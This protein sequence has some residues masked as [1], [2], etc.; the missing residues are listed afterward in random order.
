MLSFIPLGFRLIRSVLA[1]EPPLEGW[2]KEPYVEYPSNFRVAHLK[3][4][5]PIFRNI[6]SVVTMVGV[7]VCFIMLI[8]GGFRFMTSGGDPKKNQAAAG[9]LTYAALGL[10]LFVLVWFILKFIKEFTGVDI[11]VFEIPN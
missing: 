1:A 6:L 5:E 3:G 10:L 4:F 7:L 11:G 9:T 8:A 2:D